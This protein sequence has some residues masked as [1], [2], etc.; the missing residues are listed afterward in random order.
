MSLYLDIMT[1]DINNVITSSL[2]YADLLEDELAGY[3]QESIRKIRTN[4]DQTTEIIRNVSTIR[5]LHEKRTTLVPVDL[6]VVI[7]NQISHFPEIPFTYHGT[8]MMVYAD[9]LLGQVFTNLIGNSRKF[10]GDEVAIT[11]TVEELDGVVEVCVVDNGPGIP[12]DQRAQVFD[13]FQKGATSKSGKGLGL[14]ITRTLV[15]WYNGTIRAD[16][17]EDGRPGT[18]IHFT[19]QRFL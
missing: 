3:Q 8:R 14:F 5:R 1:H 10:A 18:A 15:E 2:A 16:D 19:L 12:D 13:R 6:D 9:D 17:R 7:R 11:I 4:I